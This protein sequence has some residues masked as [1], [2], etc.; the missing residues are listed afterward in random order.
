VT[1]ISTIIRTE[2][3]QGPSLAR[4][5]EAHR[6]DDAQ[7]SAAQIIEGAHAEAERLLA[8]ADAEVNAMKADEERQQ[9]QR[10]EEIES[11]RLDQIE[12]EVKEARNLLASLTG[13]LAAHHE[14]RMEHSQVES[15]ELAIAIAS[16]ILRREL[17]FD[18]RS[19]VELTHEALAM[20]DDSRQ[21]TVFVHPEDLQ[22]FRQPLERLLRGTNCPTASL[23]SDPSISRGGC[24]LETERGLIDQTVETQLD[25]ITEELLHA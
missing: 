7:R 19:V 25:R 5:R 2:R 22:A 8:V 1:T 16:R 4:H 3:S 11:L 10:R 21:L 12:A 9:K 23:E 20:V 15:L 17:T 13:D 14:Q 24:R 6:T 18:S